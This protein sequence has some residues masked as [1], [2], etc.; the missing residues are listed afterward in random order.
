MW[1]ND[2]ERVDMIVEECSR[3]FRTFGGGQKSDWNPIVNALTDK[4]PSFAAGV[5]VREVVKFILRRGR[6]LG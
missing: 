3:I 6:E 5:D 1:M 4:E 2:S